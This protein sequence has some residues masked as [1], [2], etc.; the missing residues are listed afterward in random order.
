LGRRE[1]ILSYRGRRGGGRETEVI[2]NLEKKK[3]RNEVKKVENGEDEKE[4]E[5]KTKTTNA[6]LFGVLTVYNTLHGKHCFIKHR[7]L[8]NDFKEIRQ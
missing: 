3:R 5:H 1:I 8:P 2:R 7:F 4:T 6:A